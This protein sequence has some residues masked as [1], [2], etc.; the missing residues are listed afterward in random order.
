MSYMFENEK[1][2]SCFIAECSQV[3]VNAIM[4]DLLSSM[5]EEIS[6][7]FDSMLRMLAYDSDSEDEI[8]DSFGTWDSVRMLS[9]V[10][11]Y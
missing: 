10:A 4:S 3:S 8:G 11:I 2:S 1:I 5:K 9:A 6:S 7:R